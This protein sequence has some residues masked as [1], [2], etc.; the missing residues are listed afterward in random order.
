MYQSINRACYNSYYVPF[1]TMV[2]ASWPPTY[3]TCDCGELVK[4][5]VH[6]C[7]LPCGGSHFENTFIWKCSHC[8]AR[9]RQIKSTF[10][11]ERMNEREE[12]VNE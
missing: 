5:I 4:H 3:V 10:D 11:F 2:H 8:G 1:H 9:Y 12:D 7:R 6:Y